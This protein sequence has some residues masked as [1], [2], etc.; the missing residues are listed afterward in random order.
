MFTLESPSSPKYAYITLYSFDNARPMS[1]PFK[2]FEDAYRAMLKDATDER[3]SDME[4]GFETEME[5][6]KEQGH[7]KL[8]NKFPD[9]ENVT[10]WLVVELPDWV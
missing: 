5:H 7:I 9:H 4:N 3:H 2:S 8:V 10:T 1:G 6:D